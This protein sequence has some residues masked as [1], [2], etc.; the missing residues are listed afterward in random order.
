MSRPETDWSI[1]QRQGGPALLIIIFKT[2]IEILKGFWPI[3]VAILFTG[4]SN[5]A[6]NIQLFVIV[7]FELVLVRSMIEFY[8]FHFQII[9]NEL[10]IRKGFLTKKTITLPLE[11]K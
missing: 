7:F 4:K 6:D 1:P 9:N 10:I 8:F 2:I 5:R 3:A 11:R